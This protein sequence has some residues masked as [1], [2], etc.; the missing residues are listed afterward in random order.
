MRDAGRRFAALPPV[1]VQ[2]LCP[3]STRLQCVQCLAPLPFEGNGVEWPR[4]ARVDDW[5]PHGLL[6]SDSA[7]F[8]V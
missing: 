1:P 2:R 7:V 5:Y 8:F 3:P 6:G 4:S